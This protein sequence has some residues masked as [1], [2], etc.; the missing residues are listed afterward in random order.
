MTYS[1]LQNDEQTWTNGAAWQ[2][3]H[4]KNFTLVPLFLF[5][6]EWIYQK[7]HSCSVFCFLSL[8]CLHKLPS[9][10]HYGRE[11]QIDCFGLI[12]FLAQINCVINNYWI[13]WINELN[14]TPKF[15]HSSHF[16]QFWTFCHW[17]ISSWKSVVSWVMALRMAMPSALEPVTL[18][19]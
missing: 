10:I 3:F 14:S 18:A 11:S 2:D 1:Y 7:R 6:P 5:A 19:K 8:F 12:N 16:S 13:G 17:N 15:T 9:N 4:L